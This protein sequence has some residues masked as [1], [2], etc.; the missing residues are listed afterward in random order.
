MVTDLGS[1]SKCSNR[2][3]HAA[4]KIVWSKFINCGQTCL[5]PDYVLVHRNFKAQFIDLLKYYIQ[6]LYNTNDYN[7]S[8]SKDYARIIN[9]DHF[10]RLK[11]LL[12]KTISSGAIVEIGNSLN[13]ANKYIPPTVLTNVSMASPIMEEEIFGPIL[14]IITFDD[15]AEAVEVI[16]GYPKPL[17]L[18][19]FS[20]KDKIVNY[21]LE[22]TSSGGVC[23]NDTIIHFSQTNLSFGGVNASGMGRAHGF[24]GFKTFSNEKAVLRHHRFSPF[25]FLYPPYTKRVQKIVDIMLKYL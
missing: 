12:E 7:L 17:A 14:P 16:R 4:Q 25:K 13:G 23:I 9:A 22:S 2:I 10:N 20:K 19:V 5:A 8:E 21:I 24:H 6:K 15:I 1:V 11:S 18:Y 3:L